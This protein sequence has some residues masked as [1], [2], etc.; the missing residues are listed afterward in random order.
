MTKNGA[1]YYYHVNGHGDVTTLTD[2]NGNVV[3]EYQYDA[4]GN[5]LSESGTMASAN[6]YRYAGY[7]YEEVT[8]LYYLNA[9]YYDASVGRFITR[10]TFHGFE[11]EPNSLNQ[12]SYAHNNPVKY[13]D[14]SG[15]WVQ[16]AWTAIKIIGSGVWNAYPVFK[17]YYVAHRYSVR[18]ITTTEWAHIVGV[19]AIGAF[20]SG[21]G[22]QIST[23]TKTF[24]WSWYQKFI[25]SATWS[26]KSFFINNASQGVNP[27]SAAQSMYNQLKNYVERAINYF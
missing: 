1:T 10:D 8:G 11:D 5:I 7:R 3:A 19:F 13:I 14:P 25:A 18:G 12:Y 20:T 6:P 15:H 22:I 4:W 17:K 16:L 26:L 21:M 27:I 24:G 9:R 2:A 23:I